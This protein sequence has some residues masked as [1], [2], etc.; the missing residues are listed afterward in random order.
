MTVLVIED[1]SGGEGLVEG[2]GNEGYDVHRQS[3]GG[4]GVGMGAG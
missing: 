1:D 3:T 4:G 2:I